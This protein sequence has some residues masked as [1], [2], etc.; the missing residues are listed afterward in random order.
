MLR[1]KIR[2]WPPCGRTLAKEDAQKQGFSGAGR[3]YYPYEPI[4]SHPKRKAVEHQDP[5]L[6]GEPQLGYL[7]G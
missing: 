2:I 6:C 4:P 1:P 7:D 3:S 5:F